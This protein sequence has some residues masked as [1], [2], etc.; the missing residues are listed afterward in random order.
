M[1]GD[2]EKVLGEHFRF[3]AACR[4]ARRHFNRTLKKEGRASVACVRPFLAR[5]Y[6]EVDVDVVVKALGEQ[7]RQGR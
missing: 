6:P 3:E 4:A 7:L 2:L 1:T 5:N